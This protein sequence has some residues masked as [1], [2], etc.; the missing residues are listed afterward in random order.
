[1]Q[2]LRSIWY[3]ISGT[4]VLVL[5]ACIDHPTASDPPRQTSPTFFMTAPGP[6][7]MA[8]RSHP[9][10]KTAITVSERIGPRGGVI[11]IEKLGVRIYFPRGA[12]SEK[13]RI[14]VRALGGS[15]VGFE[16]EPHGLIFDVPVEIRIDEDSPLFANHEDFDDFDVEDGSAYTLSGL[17]GVY[18]LGDPATGVVPLEILPIY[19]DGDE[20]VL[21]I[22]HFSGYAVASG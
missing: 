1:M 15:V 4:L 17:M 5:F 7:I 2:S 16:F 14:T 22:I 10:L 19:V 20:L 11:E 12:L 8:L 3:L 18:F 13:I 9:P 6:G 21:E